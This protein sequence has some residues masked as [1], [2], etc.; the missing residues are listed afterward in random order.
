TNLIHNAIQ[1][2][3]NEGEL[4]IDVF[5]DAGYVVTQITDSGAGIP[6]EIK[7]RIFEPFF[8]TKPAGE[9]SGLG[10]DIVRKIVEKHD[11]TIEVDSRPGRTTFRVLLPVHT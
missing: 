5:Q 3:D 6:D 2:M 7:D 1:A 10:L 4:Q 11:G 8:T 9:G